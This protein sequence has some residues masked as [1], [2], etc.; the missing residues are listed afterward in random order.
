MERCDPDQLDK[1]NELLETM[2]GKGYYP[3]IMSGDRYWLYI[4]FVKAPME[5]QDVN[6]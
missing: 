5:E 1:C 6:T 4:I 2:R 3:A